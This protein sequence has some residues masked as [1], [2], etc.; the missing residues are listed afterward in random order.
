MEEVF[1]KH[2][3]KTLQ[4]LD[5]VDVVWNVIMYSKSAR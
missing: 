2:K 5:I 3:K 4:G 1:W